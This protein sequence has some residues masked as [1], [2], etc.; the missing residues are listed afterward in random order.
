M[1]A[2]PLLKNHEEA[3][4]PLT[5]TWDKVTI[6]EWK[7]LCN[8][9][10]RSNFLMT[11]LAAKTTLQIERKRPQFG[12]FKHNGTPVALV[13]LSV[14]KFWFLEKI[15]VHR[16]PLWLTK[17]PP[18]AWQQH[19]L[20][21]LMDAWPKKTW[22]RL[23]FMPEMADTAQNG[24]YLLEAGF[25]KIRG[26]H[27]RSAWLDL[28]PSV[29]TLK[30]N[31]KRGWRSALKKAE[32]AELEIV[33]DPTFMG[34]KLFLRGYVKDKKQK[35]YKG[36]SPRFLL[37][38]H[39]NARKDELLLLEAWHQGQLVGAQLFFIHGQTA[40]YFV[41]WATPKGRQVAAHNGLLFNAIERLKKMKIRTLDL[42]GLTA[43]LSGVN[44]FK[45]GLNGQKYTLI[46]SWRHG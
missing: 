17:N 9:S 19:A 3:P 46:G 29:A 26:P 7:A 43:G 20:Q 44:T 35:K 10:P 42:G 25:K 24:Q 31:L 15:Y 12:V 4:P 21:S 36:P 34:F 41:G 39:K 30:Q 1:T 27:Y 45:K 13:V 6:G 5:L 14:W 37:Q 22:R 16:G 33:A 18:M 40:T 23:F 38:L 11:W 32:K 8:Q 28:R 2:Q